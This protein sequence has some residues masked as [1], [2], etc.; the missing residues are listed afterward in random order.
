MVDGAHNPGAMQAFVESVKA[1][2][3]SER[4]EMIL[5]FSA[6]SDK[7]YDEMIEYLCG[8]LDV[9]A[10]I[11]TQIEDERGVPVEEL[12]DIFR[13]YT[14]RPVYCKERLK[15]PSERHWINGGS[16]ERYTVLVHYTL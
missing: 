3:E 16:Q 14:D 13:R 12:A 1:L 11:V 10:Y 5:L 2:D 6:V 9:K 4:G 8:N 15:M 7:K